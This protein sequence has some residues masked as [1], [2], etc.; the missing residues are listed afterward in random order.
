MTNENIYYISDL[1]G[2]TKTIRNSAAESF[3]E[4]H[5]EN[6]DDYITL[7]QAKKLVIGHSLGQDED[8]NYLI[9][10]DV[11]DDTFNDIREWIYEAGLAKLAAKGVIDCAWDDDNNQMI[12]WV[13]DNEKQSS[14]TTETG[15][16]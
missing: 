2:Y 9:D 3:A 10:A 1:D 11:F 4:N 6:L 13:D 14:S 15:N 5:Q 8:G 12:F 7:E 16:R